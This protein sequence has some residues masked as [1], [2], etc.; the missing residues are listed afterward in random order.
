MSGEDNQNAITALSGAPT[1]SK[2]A[3]LYMICTLSK[4]A[5]EA[6][7]YSDALMLDWRGQLAETTGANMFL[8]MDGQVRVDTT[9]PS[10]KVKLAELGHGACVGE[11]SVVTQST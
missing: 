3:G 7:G 2:A 11:V 1:A 9:G 6:K 5:A 8:V 10:G 4:H